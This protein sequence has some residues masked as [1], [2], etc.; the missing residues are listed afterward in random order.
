MINNFHQKSVHN[1]WLGRSVYGAG[2]LAPIFSLG[3]ASISALA[4]EPSYSMF[5][6]YISALGD[7]AS[8]SWAHF[9]NY[10][11]MLGAI[12]LAINI[13]GSS[14]CVN[15][16]SGYVVAGIG[17]IS[18]VGMFFIGVFPSEPETIKG[19]FIAAAIGFL[20]MLGLTGSFSIFILTIEQHVLP[21]WLF[22][23]SIFSVICILT[24][25]FIIVGKQTNFLSSDILHIGESGEL[26]LIKLHASF[27][28]FAFL[29]VL[30][31]S[32]C[33]ALALRKNI[34]NHRITTT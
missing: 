9:F 13:I 4:F 11:M 16:K 8:T 10:G 21:K 19:H 12:L 3:G 6:R 7:S 26:P 34:H 20:G 27:E 18:T 24:F 17:L 31:W 30:L 2:L 33:T 22:I 1:K 25:I 29:S 14:L 15:T 28:W 5:N 32:T 23:P